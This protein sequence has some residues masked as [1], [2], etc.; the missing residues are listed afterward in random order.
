MKR[1]SAE[2]HMG[3]AI[4]HLVAGDT[5]VLPADVDHQILNT[6]AEPLELIA[7]FTTSPVQTVAPDGTAIDLPW[8]S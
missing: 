8:R 6:D 4:R 1:G 3:G 2:L 5:V 7:V